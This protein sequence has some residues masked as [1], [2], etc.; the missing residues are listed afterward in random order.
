MAII[1]V[2]IEDQADGSVYYKFTSDKTL[3]TDVKL[4]TPAQVFSI[5]LKKLMDDLTEKL[6]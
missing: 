5:E 3:P 1:S 4:L 6:V 2:I